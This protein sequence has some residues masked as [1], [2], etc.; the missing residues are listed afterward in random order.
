[1]RST[2]EFG[3]RPHKP[4]A[5]HCSTP[6]V[7]ALLPHLS[8]PRSYAHTRSATINPHY[9]TKANA[10]WWALLLKQHCA[11][12]MPL[13]EVQSA[14]RAQVLPPHTLSSN[15]NG[16]ECGTISGAMPEQP[17]DR[18]APRGDP[19][20]P[21]GVNLHPCSTEPG[22]ERLA[23]IVAAARSAAHRNTA[24][25]APVRSKTP[26]SLSGC[27]MNS[28]TS[29]ENSGVRQSSDQR[30]RLS[31]GCLRPRAKMHIDSST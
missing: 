27:G 7:L 3:V 5:Q 1:M 21:T 12:T 6:H 30:R 11:E 22:S 16:F 29:S 14:V 31:R 8:G 10:L 17:L 2:E 24:S 4:K 15:H 19:F 13:A 23:T 20:G 18:Q 25:M 28:P 26:T 9:A